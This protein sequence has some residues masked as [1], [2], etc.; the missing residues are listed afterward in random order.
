M[1]SL[2]CQDVVILNVSPSGDVHVSGVF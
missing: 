2:V 1:P